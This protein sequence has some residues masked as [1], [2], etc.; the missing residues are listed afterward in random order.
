MPEG[1]LAIRVAAPPF[2]IAPGAGGLST[3]GVR[4]GLLSLLASAA[5]AGA[6]Y[7]GFAWLRAAREQPHVVEA[8]IG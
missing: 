5:I 8:T 6:A 4:G 2:G 7:A 3:L 1:G